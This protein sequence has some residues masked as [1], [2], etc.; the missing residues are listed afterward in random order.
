[1][2]RGLLLLASILSLLALSFIPS[3]AATNYGNNFG[4]PGAFPAHP[5]WT[6]GA[7]AT[8]ANAYQDTITLIGIADTVRTSNISTDGWDFS[9]TLGANAA[10]FVAHMVATVRFFVPPGT[11]AADSTGTDS[12]YFAIEPS[13]DGGKTYVNCT[14]GVKDLGGQAFGNCAAL[15]HP[16]SG[17]AA[18][19]GGLEY[20]GALI[21]D[22]DTISEK[23]VFG[24]HDFRLKVFSDVVSNGRIG[25]L[26]W[27]VDPVSPRIAN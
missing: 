5:Q 8:S 1:M 25:P 26:Q 20:V 22:L 14:S 10:S 23:N 6:R 19:T 9:N 17:V 11:L 15:I 24:L 12:I 16:L 21:V 13:F 18:G 27:R 2:K 3:R 7:G 4:G